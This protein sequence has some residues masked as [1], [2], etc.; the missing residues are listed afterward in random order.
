MATHNVKSGQLQRWASFDANSVESIF[1]VCALP[2]ALRQGV[3]R[4]ESFLESRVVSHQQLPQGERSCSL[5]CISLSTWPS[6]R[7]YG[8]ILDISAIVPL[9]SRKS[10][11]VR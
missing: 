9:E 11:I 3:G 7:L 4:F 1:V 10:L 5:A 8:H 6:L 2:S